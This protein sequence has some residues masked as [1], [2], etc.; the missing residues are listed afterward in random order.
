M[1]EKLNPSGLPATRK[2]CTLAF[3]AA[4]VRQVAA[5]ARQNDVARARGILSALLAA[6]RARIAP[7]QPAP[8]GHRSGRHAGRAF[9]PRIPRFWPR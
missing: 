7:G 9:W 3:K 5:G 2:K 4:C 8:L 6:C 1:T